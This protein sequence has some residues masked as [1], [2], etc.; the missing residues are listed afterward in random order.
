MKCIETWRNLPEVKTVLGNL[1]R[2]C[3][4]APNLPTHIEQSRVWEQNPTVVPVRL[5]PRCCWRTRVNLTKP[6]FYSVS[7]LWIEEAACGLLDAYTCL[8]L[9]FEVN[10][11]VCTCVSMPTCMG[12]VV[13]GQYAR[14]SSHLPYPVGAEASQWVPFL[15]E[16][17]EAPTSLLKWND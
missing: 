10:F 17:D 9:S 3:S 14:V 16:P 13:R 6:T 8:I 11:F 2:T 5:S 1:V 15:T 4:A 12:V 7:Y